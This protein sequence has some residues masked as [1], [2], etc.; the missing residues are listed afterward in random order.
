MMMLPQVKRLHKLTPQPV[1]DWNHC[2][3][4]I[5]ASRDRAAFIELFKHFAPLLKGFLLKSGG[6]E[7]GNAEE[8]VQET[9]LKVWNKA[10]T[11]VAS[12]ASASTWIYT[13]ARNTR[14]DWFRKQAR[15]NPD[16]LNADDLYDEQEAPSA[17]SSIVQLRNYRNIHEQL[18][19]LPE[20]QSEVIKLMYFKG[21]SGSEV[22]TELRIPIGT[23]KSRIRLAL[24]KMRIKLAPEHDAAG[25]IA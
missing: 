23:V 4:S 11:Y 2:L 22:A 13:I 1:Q 19:S 18:N 7:Q 10:P 3:A 14:I 12:Q 6:L 25:D 9:M 5:G 21:K 15:Q 24:N 20:E 16:K 8:L 17:L